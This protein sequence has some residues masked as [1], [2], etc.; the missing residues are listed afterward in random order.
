MVGWLMDWK[1][2]KARGLSL[3]RVVFR[4]VPGDTEENHKKPR[5]PD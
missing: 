5:C 4:N 1:G 3:S 2:F